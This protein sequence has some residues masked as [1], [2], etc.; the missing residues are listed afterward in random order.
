MKLENNN[1]MIV[2]LNS[3]GHLTLTWTKT[4]DKEMKKLIEKKLVEGY[5]FFTLTNYLVYKKKTTLTNVGKLSKREITVADADLACFLE[6]NKS[7]SISSTVEGNM[8][9]GTIVKKAV[10]IITKPVVAVRQYVGG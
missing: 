3:F 8:N 7:A 9:T 2:F 10:D 6:K 1:R 4:E 5:T